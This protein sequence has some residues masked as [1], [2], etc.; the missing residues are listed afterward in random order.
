MCAVIA[1]AIFFLKFVSVDLNQSL[2][3]MF[4]IAAYTNVTYIYIA[5]FLLRHKITA[6]FDSLTEIYEESK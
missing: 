6:V 5:A 1:S 3:A 4:Q 2:Y